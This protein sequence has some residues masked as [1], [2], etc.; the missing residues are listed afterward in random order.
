MHDIDAQISKISGQ[1]NYMESLQQI[2]G[3]IMTI[4]ME[5]FR[6]K[7]AKLCA[8]DFNINLLLTRFKEADDT[9]NQSANKTIQELYKSFTSLSSAL[10]IKNKTFETITKKRKSKEP[11]VKTQIAF[12]YKPSELV[13]SE[14]FKQIKHIE[15]NVNKFFNTIYTAEVKPSD[16]KYEKIVEDHKQ[17]PELLDIRTCY[18]IKLS[19][20]Q[21]FT[22]F[23]NLQ[24]CCNVIINILMFPMYDVNATI[25]KHWPKISNI[26]KMKS[27]SQ[28]GNLTPTDII[29]M[30]EQFIV[31]KYR[32]TV[33]G[34]NKHYVKLFMNT[35]GNENISKMDGARFMEIMDSI[36][37]DKLDKKENVYKF[38]LTAKNTMKKIINN[39]NINAEEMLAEMDRLFNE[40]PQEPKV[41]EVENPENDKYNDII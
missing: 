15:K 26:F 36:D 11:K 22:N 10:D 2:T 23:V 30:L 14:W 34:N 32:A 38:A 40:E 29:N 24:K 4:D 19:S 13:K 28:L 25:T 9:E 18:D 35:V 1:E 27:F 37:L 6:A 33:T 39:E 5:I 17:H 3:N 41:T 12:Q 16:R 31:A 21:V 20:E 8:C 7:H